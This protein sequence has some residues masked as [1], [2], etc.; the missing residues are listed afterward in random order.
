MFKVNFI[1]GRK[2]FLER[3]LYLTFKPKSHQ[4][5]L[6][7]LLLN[8]ELDYTPVVQLSST[9]LH[10]LFYKVNEYFLWQVTFISI[11]FSTCY[12]FRRELNTLGTLPLYMKTILKKA[13]FEVWLGFLPV[14]LRSISNTST[15][16][17]FS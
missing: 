1:L 4:Y 16:P 12:F 5:Y 13:L 15:V 9:E 7:D 14:N 6:E 2:C 8:K 17:H 11:Y 10:L 3:R